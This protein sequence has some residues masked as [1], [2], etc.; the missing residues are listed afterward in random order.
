MTSTAR[1]TLVDSRPPAVRWRDAP[2]PHLVA[3]LSDVTPGRALDVGC[4]DGADAR[5]LARHGW[6][7]EGLDASAAS[8]ERAARRVHETAPE[9]EPA[10]TWRHADVVDDPPETEGYDLVA[11]QVGDVPAGRLSRVVHGLASAV[12]RTGTLLVVGHAEPGVSAASPATVP[13]ADEVAAL[14]DGSW[15]VDVCGTRPRTVAVDGEPVTVHDTVVRATR[16]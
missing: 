2:D 8:L 5:W 14:L 16:L 9:L 6:Q 7:V 11:C 1:Q 13:T 12:R 10:I 15:L 4:S 3:Q